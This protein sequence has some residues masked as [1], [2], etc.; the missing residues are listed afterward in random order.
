M[1][2]GLAIAVSL[3]LLA[4]LTFDVTGL[5]AI[6]GDPPCSEDCP[7]GASDGPCSPVCSF[8]GCCSL[9]R[10]APP[11]IQLSMLVNPVA[12][13]THA[14]GDRLPPSPD[15]TPIPHVPKLLA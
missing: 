2:H 6:A 7:I 13:S 10:V 8:C 15:P 12:L 4:L 9:P 5:S 11:T 3:V 1:A 14:P